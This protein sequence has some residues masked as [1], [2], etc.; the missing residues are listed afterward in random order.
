MYF[1]LV[2]DRNCTGNTCIYV[3]KAE[4]KSHSFLI[5]L[6]YNRAMNSKLGC[7]QL[8]ENYEYKVVAPYRSR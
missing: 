3:Q 7:P 8:G 2:A 5:A 6:M 1:R 4:F